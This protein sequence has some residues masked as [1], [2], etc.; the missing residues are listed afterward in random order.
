MQPFMPAFYPQ[1]QPPPP[2][3]PPRPQTPQTQPAKPEPEPPSG[4][5]Y[6][7]ASFKVW[8]VYTLLKFFTI[9]ADLNKVLLKTKYDF[10]N[11]YFAEDLPAIKEQCF[12]MIKTRLEPLITDVID[13]H[14]DSGKPI[15][16]KPLEQRKRAEQHSRPG[17]GRNARLGDNQTKPAVRQPFRAEFSGQHP[18]QGILCTQRLLHAVRV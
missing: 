4:D 11:S 14:P 15:F 13:F 9:K 8:K 17:H 5:I 2:V 12:L 10:S 1:Y 16:G 7:Q 3:A 6:R 18:L